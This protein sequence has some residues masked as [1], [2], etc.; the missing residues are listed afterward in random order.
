MKV[1]AFWEPSGSNVIN[2]CYI[3]D[4][5]DVDRVRLKVTSSNAI[6]KV[7][8]VEDRPFAVSPL[9]HFFGEAIV[10]DSNSSEMR[11]DLGRCRAIAR[12]FIRN[13]ARFLVEA[14]RESFLFENVYVY[15]STTIESEIGSC[16]AHVDSSTTPAE[17]FECVTNLFNT[18][19]LPDWYFKS[20]GIDRSASGG[21]H[22]A[23]LNTLDLP[24]VDTEVG[25]FNLSNCS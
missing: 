18:F 3:P 8:D 12:S 2:Q 24:A 19:V 20:K 16:L 14:Q 23:F 5:D 17:L 13:F 1:L 25:V 7:M 9:V 6:Y 11:L 21:H 10:C 4:T 15:A 22:F